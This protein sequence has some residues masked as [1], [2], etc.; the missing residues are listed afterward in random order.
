MTKIKHLLGILALYFIINLSSCITTSQNYDE[1][2]PGVWR[3]ELYLDEN[4]PLARNI[5]KVGNDQDITIS[6][7]F[8]D[9]VLPFNFLVSYMGD[10]MVVD[11]MNGSDTVRAEETFYG[12]S[13]KTGRDTVRINF[14]AFDT[15]IFAEVED[16]IMTGAWYN[17]RKKWR[18]PF[19]GLAGKDYR[20]TLLKDKPAGD[21][22]GK[23]KVTFESN[24]ETENL[25]GQFAQKLNHLTG[26]FASPTGDYGFMEGTVQSDR[27]LLS[28]FNGGTAYLVTGKIKD[29]DHIEGLFYSGLTG[30]A[31]WTAIRQDS[32]QLPDAG[33]L[34]RA[35]PGAVANFKF[36]DETGKLISLDDP[37]FSG[38]PKIITIMGTW[39][40][41]CKDEARFLKEY[42][43]NHQN[44]DI[45]VIA[46]AF[47][48]YRDTNKVRTLLKNYRKSLQLPYPILWAG[49]ADKEAS[50]KV[51]FISG[52]KAYPTMIFLDRNNKVVKVS[53]G[54]SG[55]A[56]LEYAVFK[57]EFSQDVV[58][59][60]K[61]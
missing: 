60:L 7:A 59:L 61:L 2:M 27:I 25:I 39:C 5:S 46:L 49:M 9:G 23:W 12:R 6:K 16:G 14:V 47:E 42:L 55:P 36:P 56:T 38:K 40:H 58:N 34:T 37:E 10:S 45:K 15:Y 35:V 13:R 11:F 20:F 57:K 3:G 29:M 1:L 18:I 22:S 26:T 8:T 33:L 43:T 19:R 24:G 44:Q 52:I 31:T 53:A 54:F 30:R 51:P 21:I 41:N 32:A 17:P 50:S 48:A 4:N 28:G